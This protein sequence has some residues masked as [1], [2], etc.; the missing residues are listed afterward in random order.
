MTHSPRLASIDRKLYRIPDTT[1]ERLFSPALVVFMDLVRANLRQMLHYLGGDPNRW[2]PHLKTT[3][4]PQVWRELIAVGVRHFK[5]ATTREAEVLLGLLDE[6]GIRDADLLVAY[7]LLPPNLDKVV[8]LA[9]AHPETR[10]SILSEHP[11]HAASLPPDVGVFVDINPQM[12]RTG[13]PMTDV[14]AIAGVARAAGSRMRGLHFYDGHVRDG[15]RQV[16]RQRSWRLYDGLVRIHA[17]LVAES[18]RVDEL[19][20]SGTP[21]FPYAL[22]HRGLAELEGLVHRVSPGTVVLHDA[23]SDDLLDDVELQPAALLFTRVVSHPE[24][25]IVTC[26]AGSKS[27]AAEA[28]SPVAFVLGHPELVPQT[29]SEEHL[30]LRVTDGPPPPRG[31]AL[32]LVPRHVCPTV[33]LAEKALV[34]ESGR[35]PVE[36]EVAARAHDVLGGGF[37]K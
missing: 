24:S 28:G 31:T 4:I 12:N 26:D 14:A 7:P 29:P 16:R 10:V 13:I 35:E 18:I 21:A 8:A 2:R 22:S 33:N 27:L 1:A 20:T 37:W 5:C 36:V 34:I 15:E 11:E 9:A 17:A 25:G 6:M 30:P 23:F 3:K 32:M 19:I